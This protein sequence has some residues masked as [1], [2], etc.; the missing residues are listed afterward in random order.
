MKCL[1]CQIA[2]FCS[3]EC[4]DD[5]ANVKK[6]ER[7]CIRCK[8][9]F[10]RHDTTQKVLGGDTKGSPPR[11]PLTREE[12]LERLAEIEKAAFRTPIDMVKTELLLKKFLGLGGDINCFHDVGWTLLHTTIG[13]SMDTREMVAM[14]IGSCGVD[15]NFR[16]GINKSTGNTALSTP[17]HLACQFGKA[18]EVEMLINAGADVNA[19][20]RYGRTPLLLCYF[21]PTAIRLLAAAGANMHA[22]WNGPEASQ[23]V[24]GRKGIDLSRGKVS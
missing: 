19:R 21:C 2:C 13:Q 14:L 7:V 11:S 6:H 23:A 17:L 5:E 1:E 4:R 22:F 15:V 3:V 12:M 24:V 20:N 8:G 9:A 10:D 18:Y 16:T